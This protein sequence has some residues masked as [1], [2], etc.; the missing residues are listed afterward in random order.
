VF[1]FLSGY[2]YLL[3]GPKE[4]SEEGYKM[5]TIIAYVLVVP[6]S[7]FFLAAGQWLCAIPTAFLLIWA[8][9]SLR[10]KVSGFCSGITGVAVAVTCGYEIF[11]LVIGPESF[12]IGAF[13]A[14]TL[15]L[16]LSIRKDLLASQRVKA[17]RNQLLGGIAERSGE[18]AAVA[19]A[20]E[21]GNPLGST[22]VGKIVGLA[23]A[24][25]WFFWR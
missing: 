18:H 10:T 7:P 6:L 20:T 5:K 4:E 2:I 9:V 13:L 15:P 25:I 19:M 16:P 24:A 22:A 8:S 3:F 14:S 21:T 11:R 12:T 23:L 17:A 1:K